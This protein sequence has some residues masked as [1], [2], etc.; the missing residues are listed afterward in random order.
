MGGVQNRSGRMETDN[1]VDLEQERAK[2]RPRFN[3]GVVWVLLYCL[4]IFYFVVMGI[5]NAVAG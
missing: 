1:V 4:I 5:R 2:R 3:W